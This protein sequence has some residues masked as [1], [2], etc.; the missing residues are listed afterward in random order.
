[1]FDVRK[2]KFKPVIDHCKGCR[3]AASFYLWASLSL[4]G[5]RIS[6]LT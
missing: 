6:N 5:K 2:N 1:M 4:E 3:I